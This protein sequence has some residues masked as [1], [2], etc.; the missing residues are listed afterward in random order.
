[1]SES[2]MEV[3]PQ[4]K[5]RVWGWPAVANFVLGGMASGFYLLHFEGSERGFVSRPQ[6]T[7][8]SLLSPLLI[9]IGFFIVTFEAGRPIRGIYLL[10]NLKNSWMSREI[11]SGTIFVVA[12]TINWLSPHAVLYYLSVVAVSVYLISQGFIIYYARAV[13]AWNVPLVPILFITS[14]LVAGYGLLLIVTSLSELAFSIQFIVTGIVCLVLN[15]SVYTFYVLLHLRNCAFLRATA[16]LRNPV[17]LIV[18]IGMGHLV[19]C[20]FLILLLSLAGLNERVRSVL[21]ILTGLAIIIGEVFQK[22]LIILGG[23]FLRGIVIEQ[24]QRRSID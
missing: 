12:A 5:K 10:G 4:K 8:F 23:N 22:T 18:T 16:I 24:M 3:V 7:I 15:L 14:G 11:L 9:M 19:P 6:D 21:F 13:T 2:R 20:I 1:M 17:S